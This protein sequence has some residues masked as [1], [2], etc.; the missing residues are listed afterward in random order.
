MGHLVLIKGH[1][2]CGCKFLADKRVVGLPDR[3]RPRCFSGLTTIELSSI[4][5]TATHRHFPKFSVVLQRDDPAERL[6][7]LTRGRG[8]QFVI[9]HGGRKIILH[10]LTAGQLFGGVTI[11]STP[12]QYLTSTELEPGSCVLV[13]DRKTVREFVFRFPILVGQRSLRRGD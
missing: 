13:W 11:L 8:K 9:T 4:L 7:L 10:W 5:S 2:S 6:F 3:L 12:S 1:V